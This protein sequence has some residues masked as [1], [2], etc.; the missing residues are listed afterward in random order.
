MLDT[1]LQGSYADV[2]IIPADKHLISN[3]IADISMQVIQ[4]M[5]C[6]VG[7]QRKLTVDHCAEDTG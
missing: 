7:V 1:L 3:N 2:E 5:H 4:A 6:N